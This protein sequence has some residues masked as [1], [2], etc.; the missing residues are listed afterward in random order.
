[1]LHHPPDKRQRRD[2][3]LLPLLGLV[4]VIPVPHPLPIVAQDASEGDRGLTTYFAK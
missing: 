1:M 3:V 2:L 4:I